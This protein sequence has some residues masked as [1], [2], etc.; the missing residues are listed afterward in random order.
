MNLWLQ[1]IQCSL[2]AT[3]LHSHSW[4]SW[5]LVMVNTELRILPPTLGG[6][7]WWEPWKLRR[8]PGM[9]C[10][11]T[12][13]E[14]KELFT[15]SLKRETL[16]MT[17]RQS[18][19]SPTLAPAPSSDV[20]LWSAAY[21][22]VVSLLLMTSPALLHASFKNSAKLLQSKSNVLLNKLYLKHATC[23]Y[24]LEC[25]ARWLTCWVSVKVSPVQVWPQCCWY[26]SNPPR[27]FPV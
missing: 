27:N 20:H 13:W 10:R 3:R 7:S 26:Q 9:C 5:R 2:A 6:S 25:F 11:G 16:A 22:K 23:I 4:W 8:S 1:L 21:Y 24:P 14:K 15:Q 19:L 17:Q 12:I 18:V